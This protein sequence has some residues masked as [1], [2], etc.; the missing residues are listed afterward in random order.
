M[1]RFWKEVAVVERDDGFG[2]ALD[3][4]PLKTPA[5]ADL[6]VA[7]CPLAEAIASEW[8]ECGETI[9]PRAMP[10]TGFANA[11]IDRIAA[12]P[13]TFAKGLA[14]YGENDLLCYRAEHPALLV[15]RQAAAWDPLLA[16]A[17]RRYDVDFAVSAGIIH[18]PQP[19]ET[20]AK[21]AQA[22]AAMERLQLA[23]LS[24]MVTIGGSLVAAL[25]VAEE[26]VTPDDAWAAVSL[27]ERWSAEQ[28]GADAEAQAML[29][30]RRRDFLAGARL[31]ELL[32][33]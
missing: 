10:L 33:A 29:D 26:A 19:P 1:K 3:G 9:D 31:L 27:D 22:V 14:R 32:R 18:V 28:W 23:G 12:D 6:V 13:A 21:L 11:A 8:S 17:R 4:R 16:W 24:P 25:T 7:S 30:A 5:R 20:I 2:I 15:E